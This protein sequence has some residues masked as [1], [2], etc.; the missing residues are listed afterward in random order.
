MQMA[1]PLRGSNRISGCVPG[2]GHFRKLIMILIQGWKLLAYGEKYKLSIPYN[3]IPICLLNIVKS[4]P[5]Y[6]PHFSKAGFFM[7]P[8]IICSPSC[9]LSTPCLFFHL[10]C[11]LP[12]S[13]LSE[14]NPFFRC[15]Y[16][17]KYP[18]LWN[19]SEL[20]ILILPLSKCLEYFMILMI[21][22]LFKFI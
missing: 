7:F 20:Q 12:P 2:H 15:L 21:S 8:S 13:L 1:M 5:S 9:L 14:S 18:S 17:E 3:W 22:F 6:T 4:L 11:P 16:T 10:Q 19:C